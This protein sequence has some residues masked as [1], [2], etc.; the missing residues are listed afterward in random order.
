MS[1]ANLRTL[2][3]TWKTAQYRIFKLNNNANLL[4]T[5]Y[6]FGVLPINFVLDL[7]KLCFLSKRRCH[8]IYVHNIFY[9]MFGFYEFN[10][11]CSVYSVCGQSRGYQ[12]G[13]FS[14]FCILTAVLIVLFFWSVCLS[15][16]LSVSTQCCVNK[17]Y[18]KHP[19]SHVSR[20]CYLLLV[21]NEIQLTVVRRRLFTAVTAMHDGHVDDQTVALLLGAGVSALRVSRHR[22]AKWQY[23]L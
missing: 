17:D 10:S 1:N 5:Q 7:R 16:C 20:C 6:C 18:H 12:P 11:L 4:Y 3:V 21:C 2:Y 14:C 23:Q 22:D 9:D 8:S 13:T 15:V 19:N